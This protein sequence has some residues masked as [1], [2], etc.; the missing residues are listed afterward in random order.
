[1]DNL[2]CL[3]TTALSGC[4]LKALPVDRPHNLGCEFNGKAGCGKTACPV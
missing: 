1:M 4:D 3:R 2:A